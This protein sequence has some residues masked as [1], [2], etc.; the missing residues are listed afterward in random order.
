MRSNS[1]TSLCIRYDFVRRYD[2]AVEDAGL[3][4]ADRLF[5]LNQQN[6]CFFLPP[7]PE[8]DSEIKYSS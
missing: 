5:N 3:V 8:T 2:P 6:L 7:A 1:R 4:G